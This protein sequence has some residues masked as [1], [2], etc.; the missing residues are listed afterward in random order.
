[1]KM[2]C[3]VAGFSSL[4]AAP[5]VLPF[6]PYIVVLRYVVFISSSIVTYA[7]YKSENIIWTLLFLGMTILLYPL[8]PI[9]LDRD[10]WIMFD[11]FVAMAFFIAGY[12]GRANV[13]AKR[14]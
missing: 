12:F 13:Q 3:L 9:I 5:K 6:A 8:M 2:V 11:I 14:D 4:C 10:G 1:M 7:F